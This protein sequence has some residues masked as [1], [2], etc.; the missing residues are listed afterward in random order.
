MKPN[1]ARPPYINARQQLAIPP[2]PGPGLGACPGRVPELD[3]NTARDS[4][5]K[6]YGASSRRGDRPAMSQRDSPVARGADQLSQ[7]ECA[8]Q[9]S[10]AELLL[11]TMCPC[12]VPGMPRLPASWQQRTDSAR[13]PAKPPARPPAARPASSHT[14]HSHLPHQAG[15]YF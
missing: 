12:C 13:A 5:A 4:Y 9:L 3:P 1:T 10:Q 14:S 6:S 11:E 2:A 15:V 8:E 7:E